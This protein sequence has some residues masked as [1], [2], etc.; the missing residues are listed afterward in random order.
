MKWYAAFFCWESMPDVSLTSGF[1]PA[2]GRPI[3]LRQSQYP[4]VCRQRS[5]AHARSPGR[6]RTSNT[7]TFKYRF[8]GAE[9]Y[10]W[11]DRGR[12][13]NGLGCQEEKDIGFFDC[14]PET[15]LDIEGE[16]VLFFQA[17]AM[18]RWSVIRPHSQ[19]RI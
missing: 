11:I 15:W 17:T 16:F 5:H 12:L 13:K 6:K 2:A 19:G 4:P 3:S 7:S 14:A 9:T 1:Y 10:G 8:S 18:H